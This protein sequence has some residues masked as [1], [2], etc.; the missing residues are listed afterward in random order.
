[1]KMF[2]KWLLGVGVG[3]AA[4]VVIGIVIALEEKAERLDKWGWR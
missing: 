1:M 4:A 3:M 2:G